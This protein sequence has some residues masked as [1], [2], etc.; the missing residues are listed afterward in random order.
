MM[1]RLLTPI[2]AVA[3][4]L[5]A[6]PSA[7]AAKVKLKLGTLAPEG[8]TWH[9]T[10]VR[11]GQRWFEASG[12]E[13]ELKIY[14]G[15]VAGDE[16]DMVRKM[17]IGQLHAATITGIG[18]GQISRTSFALQVPMMYESQEELY[19]VRDKIGPKIAADLEKNGFVVLS[20]GDAGWAHH[21]SK[22]PAKTA[23]DF[24]QLK[25][26]VWNGDPESEAAWRMAKFNVVPLSVTDVQAGLQTGLVEAFGTTPLYALTSTWYQQAK[27]MVPVNWVFLNGATVVSKKEWDK[28]DPAVQKKL[29]EISNEEAAKLNAEVKTLNE[30]A[31][32][33]MKERGLTVAEA[34]AAVVQSWRDAAV[35]AYPAIRGKVVPAELFDE[36]Q[37]AAKAFRAAH[38]KK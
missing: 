32:G 18:L 5:A 36:A 21:F 35:M 4:A 10:L 1:N 16:G 12:K 26:F 30:K 25:Y 8:S 14:P 17:K 38:P 29:I 37:A 9:T 31:I 33:T 34:D 19:D 20:W 22:K 6:A 15:G 7:E 2:A 24:R 28:I 27:Y 11:M 23:D 3:L 13:V